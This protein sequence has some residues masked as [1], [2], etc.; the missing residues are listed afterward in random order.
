ELLF[1]PL[2]VA[3][4]LAVGGIALILLERRPPAVTVSSIEALSY[5]QSF[6]IG[7]FQTLALWPGFSRAGATIMGGMLL[8]L[9][10]TVAA[11]FSFLVAVPVMFAATLYDLYKSYDS[12]GAGAFDELAIGFFVS[13]VVA[14]LAIR[15]FIG[16]LKKFSLEVFGWYRIVL[17]VIVVALLSR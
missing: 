1:H 2:P 4:A 6:F 17:A 7:C 12:L 8:G 10:R 16:L 14:L 9:E 13:W 15:T 3:L 11:E 5:K